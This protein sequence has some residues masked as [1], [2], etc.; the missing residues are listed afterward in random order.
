MAVE[1]SVGDSM[2][3][4]SRHL[5]FENSKFNDDGNTLKNKHIKVDIPA[6]IS[7]VEASIPQ[8]HRNVL[9]FV[10]V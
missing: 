9:F 6:V 10:I 4:T 1:I 5:G 7:N 8:V 2:R 3:K